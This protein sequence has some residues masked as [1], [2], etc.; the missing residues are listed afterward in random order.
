MSD[1][2]L[3]NIYMVDEVRNNMDAILIGDKDEQSRVLGAVMVV[4][5]W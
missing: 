3:L 4:I 2:I 5:L 1:D